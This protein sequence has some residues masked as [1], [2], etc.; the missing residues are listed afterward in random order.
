M[1][2]SLVIGTS[3]YSKCPVGIVAKWFVEFCIIVAQMSGLSSVRTSVV[4]YSK[5]CNLWRIWFQ[6]YLCFR[7][8]S[9]GFR[10]VWE[11]FR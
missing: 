1:R 5:V 9:S 8:D 2:F 7:I 4:L 11:I 6:K 3:K 10:E